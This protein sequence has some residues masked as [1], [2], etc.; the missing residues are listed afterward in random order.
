MS[1]SIRYV[2]HVGVAV[3]LAGQVEARTI[4]HMH[5]ETARGKALSLRLLNA[6]DLFFGVAH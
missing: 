6:R 1:I 5:F 4:S 2:V 3:L